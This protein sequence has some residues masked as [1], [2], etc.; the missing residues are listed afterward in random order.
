M[1]SIGTR[2]KY[3]LGVAVSAMMAA[4][5]A[6]PARAQTANVTP[7]TVNVLNLL[8]PFLSLN[9]TAIGQQTL[10]TDLSQ[11]VAINQNASSVAA[12]NGYPASTTALAAVA[13][14]DENLLG[15]ASNTVYGLPTSQTFGPAANLAGG[16]PTQA[17][18]TYAYTNGAQPIGGFGS[19][20]G[21]AY[22]A[23][24][25]PSAPTL[26]NTITLLT[27]ALG[28]TGNTLST[29]DSQ[30]AKFYFA[31][32]TINGT[33]PAVAPSGYTLPTFNGLPNTT[34]SVYDTAFGVTNKQ[35]GQNAYGDSHPYQ[36]YTAVSTT[37]TLYDPTVKTATTVPGAVNPDKPSS[38]PAFPS[39]HMAYAMTDSILLGMAV[40]ELYQSML[41]RA[42]QM[43]DSRVVVGVHY[44]TD[45]IGSRAFASYD[46][47]QYLSNPA[48]IN[49]AAVTGTAVNL[50][51]LFTAAQSELQTQ[52][53]TAAANASCGTSLASCASSSANVNPYAPSSTNQTIYD[54]RQ[55]YGLPT[56][57]FAQAPQEQ[58]PAGGPDASILLATVYGGNTAAAL[59]LAP[60]GG[61]YGDLTTA[62]INQIIVDT[63]TQA[64]AAFYGTSLSY[65]S[66]LDLYDAIGYF[67]STTGNLTL[68]PTDQVL[69]NVVVGAG[70]MLN[71]TGTI[72]TS[73][74]PNSLAVSAGGIVFPGQIGE[75]SGGVL[76]VNGAAAFSAGSALYAQGFV[77]ANGAVST[78]GLQVN[79]NLTLSNTA[80]VTLFGT[81]LPGR[82]YNLID[83]TGT[84]TGNFASPAT[85]EQT[86]ASL[87]AGLVSPT[88][89]M[90]LVSASL[91]VGGD[92][93]VFT[94][95]VADFAA[96]AAT[97]NQRAVASAIDAAGNAGNYGANGAIALNQLIVNNTPASA[98]AAF[99]ALSGE[100][101]TGA[102]Q[103]ALN[104]A[105]GF[106]AA[107]LSQV[108][109]LAGPASGG[110]AWATGLGGSA[111]Q[112]GQASQGSAA[113]SGH[114]S[115]FAAGVDYQV[116]PQIVVG[117]AGGT[118]TAGFSV[119]GRSTTGMLDGAHVGLYAN[120][121]FGN[122]YVAGTLDYASFGNTTNRGV[123][124][125]GPVEAEVG[126][127]NSD[128]ELGRIE[129]GLRSSLDGVNVT[130][131]GGAQI[132]S[133]NLAG[134]SES[135]VG[136][137]GVLGV[138]AAAKS[139]ASDKIFLGGQVDASL[140][141]DGAT[142]TPFA[143]LAWEHEFSTTRSL[144]NAL[145]ALPSS[146][147][148][149]GAPAASD[150]ARLT[151]GAQVAL[152]ANVSI[153]ATLDGEFA[154]SGSGYSAN[155]GIRINW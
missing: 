122:L 149:Y 71:G 38:N 104:A 1:T 48:Y 111:R 23:G 99:D 34:N 137:S 86:P 134:F 144:S 92:P 25:S 78:D 112:S 16:L 44:P 80:G 14:S 11:A 123:V 54:A 107:V 52:L 150:A 19:I 85:F 102:Q 49:N 82:H 91:Q 143:R 79:G 66:R 37:Y 84:V 141:L 148:V 55:T 13:I 47:A 2:G 63:E 126:R 138:T 26:T 153:Y 96:A 140:A 128:E 69:T 29:G 106:A 6:G 100:G 5:A 124:G 145:T 120:A 57:T 139:V 88:D 17:T 90:Q 43:G 27:T 131:F 135:S 68:A 94:V 81:Y 73:V 119:S 77:A 105:D 60:T 127:F 8:A 65:W 50:P 118:S 59:A 108:T 45:I 103:A 24:V 133:L 61:M 30:V 101:L 46:L 53:T 114:N 155:G 36:T 62:T 39:S 97:P 7:A 132:A 20:L 32:G 72:G 22:V 115:G 76:T 74:A 121:R 146:F 154:G 3:L 15:S 42:S 33:T 87:T 67:G 75:T 95:P 64:L 93:V 4:A 40:P 89:L 9:S 129:A 21:A 41:M 116:A 152:N 31:N 83:V 58:A 109:T 117:F 51:S 12:I 142:F 35:A 151:A 125:V 10:Q 110:H 130:P 113:F 28:F 70:S 56:L 98:P 147:T 136:G 18:G